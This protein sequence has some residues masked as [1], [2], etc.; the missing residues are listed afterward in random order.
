MKRL[1]LSTAI[2]L[3]G[4][5]AVT[6]QTGKETTAMS[7][8]QT[9]VEARVENSLIAAHD[10]ETATVAEAVQDYKEVRVSELPQTVKDAVAKNYS[11][12]TISQAYVNAKG[13]Y[14]LELT[15]ADAKKTTVKVDKNGE[16]SKK[17]LKK[18]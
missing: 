14:K 12:T 18:Q 10:A 7:E 4:L 15:S 16:L 17:E 11:G 3:G 13:E 6:A 5:T 2:V 9:T 8:P 1:I